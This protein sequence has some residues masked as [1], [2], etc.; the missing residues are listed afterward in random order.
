VGEPTGSSP[1]FV[2]ESTW[3]PLPYHKNRV[4]CSSRYWQFRTSTDTRTWIPPQIAAPLSFA[5]YSA[6]RDP[7]MSAIEQAIAALWVTVPAT[8]PSAEAGKSSSK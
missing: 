4:Y 2:G 8:T 7:A 5:D 1:N 6:N 3:F